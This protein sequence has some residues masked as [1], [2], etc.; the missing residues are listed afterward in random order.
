MKAGRIL[1]GLGLGALLLLLSGCW[2][3]WELKDRGLVLGLSVDGAPAG[4]RVGVQLP[5]EFQL[6]GG[7][8]AGA[9]GPGGVVFTAEG[10]DL[11]EA[12]IRIGAQVGRRLYLGHV[13]VIAIGEELARAGLEHLAR[14]LLRDPE[15]WPLAVMVVVRGGP[16]L[17]VLR[18]PAEMEPI[19]VMQ[20]QKLVRNQ[21]RLGMLADE[22]LER[23]YVDARAPGLEPVLPIVEI[24]PAGIMVTG[25]AVFR[26]F[27]M[28]GSL[29][30][31]ETRHLLSLTSR[32]TGGRIALPCPGARP[33][34]VELTVLRSAPSVSVTYTEAG[35][36]VDV[37]TRFSA[38]L[39]EHPC[40]DQLPI[41]REVLEPLAARAVAEQHAGLIRR[42]QRELGADI[43]GFGA[44]IR[45]RRPELVTPEQW[46]PA[47]RQLPV[48]VSASVGIQRF[49][50]IKEGR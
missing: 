21:I 23:F 13:Q 24:R 18:H 12:L 5:V 42:V 11:Q 15:V 41:T 20:T 38:V 37:H 25:S 30:M 28:V 34:S 9:Q 33:G 43:F 3:Q 6:G 31:A 27:R 1:A 45:G 36:R 19:P 39:E 4:F 10:A 29:D 50:L 16:G 26:D 7:G 47:F 2:D 32:R 46:P 44:R 14:R 48:S 35:P 22:P 49:G 40:R 17:D 8:G